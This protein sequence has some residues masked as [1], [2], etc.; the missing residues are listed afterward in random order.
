MLVKIRFAKKSDK[1]AILEFTK[2]TWDGYDYIS[3]VIDVWLSDKE[4]QVLVAEHNH[5]AVALA[6]T[7][8]LGEGI[9]WLEGLRVAKEIRKLGVGKL[10]AKAQLESLKA[11]E[12]KKI[13]LSS[14]YLNH[15]IP[16]IKKMGFELI[17]EYTDLN[18]S[19][20]KLSIVD[21]LQTRVDIGN[22]IACFEDLKM[23]GLENSLIGIDWVFKNV[24]LSMLGEFEQD[25]EL[26]RMKDTHFILT[27]KHVKDNILALVVFS[28]QS[29]HEIVSYCIGQALAKKCDG[30]VVMSNSDEIIKD[31]KKL[32]FEVESDV[33]RSV[34]VYEMD[35]LIL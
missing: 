27:K 32:D 15:S 8:H 14:Y 33:N 3:N 9:Y 30:I 21:R 5:Q 2:D 24:S 12:P 6:R 11:L 7:T 1:E 18:Y 23:R 26:L 13:R 10:I 29:I 31:L 35:G 4:G 20:S 19:V 34:F 25:S 22:A 17:G 16:I 28:N